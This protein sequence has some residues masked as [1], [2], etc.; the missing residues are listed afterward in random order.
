[1]P[2][3]KMYLINRFF[4]ISNRPLVYFLSLFPLF[5]NN[6]FGAGDKM[7]RVW[8]IRP[9]G[10]DDFT[11]LTGGAIVFGGDRRKSIALLDNVNSLLLGI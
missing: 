7:I 11:P 10:G 6:Q 2:A 4:N 1:M 3:N 9:V 8:Q 5:G